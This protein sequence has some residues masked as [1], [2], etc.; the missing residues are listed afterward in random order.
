MC[1]KERAGAW[2]KKAEQVRARGATMRNQ[3]ARQTM[4]VVSNRYAA[5]AKRMTAVTARWNATRKR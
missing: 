3:L 4:L 1:G 5:L 2:L